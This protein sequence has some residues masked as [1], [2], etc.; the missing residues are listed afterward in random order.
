MVKLLICTL[1]AAAPRHFF[2]LRG[3][4]RRAGR[5][6][7]PRWAAPTAGLA[8]PAAP[9]GAAGELVRA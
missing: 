3:P 7:P 1:S 4:A 5:R 9:G 2:A 6:P 8:R